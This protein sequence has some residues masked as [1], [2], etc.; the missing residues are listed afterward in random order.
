MTT[1]KRSS[2]RKKATVDIDQL[3]E[4][5]LHYA[6]S[7]SAQEDRY[8]EQDLSK[9]IA[10]LLDGMDD[11]PMMDLL[12]RLQ[13]DED[14]EAAPLFI[15]LL[16]DCCETGAGHFT[17]HDALLISIPIL[18]WSRYRISSLTLPDDDLKTLKSYLQ[19]D[20]LAPGVKLAMANYLFSADQLPPGFCATTAFVRELGDACLR[21]QDLHIPADVLPE[22][23]TFLSDTRYVLAIAMAEKNAPIFTWQAQGSREQALSDWLKHS[24]P[25]LSRLMAGSHCEFQLPDAFFAATRSATEESRRYALLA[26]VSFLSGMLE[27][28]PVQLSV[29]V[30]PFGE[31]EVEEW[32]VAFTT[33][34]HEGILHG[35]VWPLLRPD[36]LQDPQ[37]TSN[38]IEELLHKAGVN[39]V[40][41]L[42][43]LSPPEIC[44]DCQAPL[45]ADA[46]GELVHPELPEDQGNNVFKLLH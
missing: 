11:Q 26:S 33:R 14:S 37:A 46:Q 27:T 31:H 5:L 44:E 12:D 7:R 21:D 43:A 25:C 18:A 13:Q 35:M 3:H 4:R 30:A 9:S 29:V 45:Y 15:D 19:Q 32:R 8:W 6:E 39:D 42:D 41:V 10:T 24:S 38:L 1:A 23:T 16:E 17:G 36:E 2:R 20:I 28:S 34:Q 40:T 22:A